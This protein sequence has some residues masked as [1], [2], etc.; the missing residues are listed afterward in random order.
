MAL[1]KVSYSLISGAPINAADYGVDSTGVTETSAQ[2]QAAIQA[3]ADQTEGVLLFPTGTYT[4]DT[5]LDFSVLPSGHTQKVIDFQNATIVWDGATVGSPDIFYL[6]NNQS[7][8]IKNFVIE[9]K[10]KGQTGIFIDSLQPLGSDLLVISDFVIRDCDIAMHIGT[11]GVSQNRV[12]ESV[13]KHFLIELCNNGFL[14]E[15]TNTDT[16]LFE[17][18]I[19]SGMDKQFWL[20]RSGFITINSVTGYETYDAFIKV[21]GPAEPLTVINCQN[22][23]SSGGVFYKR[24]NYTSSEFGATTFI[25]CSADLPIIFDTGNNVLNVSYVGGYYT[26]L[27]ITGENIRMSLVGTTA[28]ST[29]TTTITGNGS[30]L[31]NHGSYILGT[32]VDTA[33]GYLAEGAGNDKWYV[34]EPTGLLSNYGTTDTVACAVGATAI[35][36]TFEK[37]F[38]TEVSALM[39]TPITSAYNTIKG[40][41]TAI[42]T[43]AFTFTI[44]NSGGGSANVQLSWQ[45]KGY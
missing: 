5:S 36:V 37:S 14:L 22:E 7:V 29:G 3:L 35:S 44:D 19:M 16:L 41:V 2:M 45:A 40:T 39:V 17:N 43:S 12:S 28:K 24:I 1:T 32:I 9:G 10:S 21:T 30:K 11:P 15:S 13:F 18:G 26:D 38:S 6:F 20:E 33:K 23:S 25:G 31:Y 42:S 8:T 4:I 27:T 34:N